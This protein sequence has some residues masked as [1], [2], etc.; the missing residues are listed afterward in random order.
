MIINLKGKTAVITGAARGIGKAI[1]LTLAKS[2][3]DLAI[4][5]LI[6][7]EAEETRSEAEKLGVR[8]NVYKADVSYAPDV[9]IVSKAILECFG[10]VDILVNNAGIVSS[11]PFLET[12]E[13]ELDKLLAVNLKGVYNTIRAL[14]PG[15]L[16]RRSGKIINIA[17]IAGKT[18]GGFF[19]NTLYG[20]TKAGV[21][22]LTK[23]VAREAGPFGVT[24][25]AV[26]PG[27]I[28]TKMLADCPNDVRQRILQ[29]VP[30]RKF[31]EAKDVA[32]VVLF[33]ASSL[34]DHMTAEITDVDG[35]IMHDG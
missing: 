17:S 24:A 10:K 18:G 35:G 16:N 23:G 5:D 30:L 11:K 13:V 15:M 29:G 12:D 2:G 20:V 32:N 6:A 19:G 34:S 4:I 3:A 1:A 25:N 28:E 26:C 33:L 31:G 21:I 22:A 27:P 8:A 14:L 9:K 7:E